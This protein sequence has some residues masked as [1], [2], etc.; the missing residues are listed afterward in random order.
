MFNILLDKLP[1]DYRGFP[2]DTD[3]QVGIQIMQVLED[4]ELSG[5]EGQDRKSVV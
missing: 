1:S 3:F 5:Q 4:R 2:I